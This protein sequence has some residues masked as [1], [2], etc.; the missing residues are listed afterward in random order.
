MTN[1]IKVDG[2][3]LDNFNGTSSATPLVAGIAALLLSKYPNLSPADIRNHLQNTADDKGVPGFD[4]QFGHGRVNAA[5]ALTAEP[6]T[7][8]SKMPRK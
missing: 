2:S 1:A 3:Y 6:V 4:Y 5:K 8:T 7:T